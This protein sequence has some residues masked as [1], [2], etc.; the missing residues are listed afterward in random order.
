MLLVILALV[1]GLSALTLLSLGVSHAAQFAPSRIAAVWHRPATTWAISSTTHLPL[2]RKGTAP[3][4]QPAVGAT[5]QWQLTGPVNQSFDVDVYDIDLFDNPASVVTAL[6]AGGHRVICYIS[7][8]SW[9]DWRPDA[10]QFPPE[11][12][13]KDYE[14]WPHEKWLDIR[15]IDVLGPIMSAR[16]DQCKANGFD[17]I[18]PDNIDGYTNDTG[19]DLSYQDQLTYNMWLAGEAHLR[20]LSIGLKNDSEQVQDLLPHYDWA[21]TEDCFFEEWC[22]DMTPFIAAGKAVFAAEYTDTGITLDDFCPQA[23]LLRFSAIL[24]HHDLDAWRQACP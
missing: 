18:E 6:H 17:A 22:D 2:I 24:K 9:E 19:F 21:L 12:I 13:G 4:W 3:V 11:V 20:G 1:C 7:V 5:W 10:N 14:G 8:G 15:R 23:K 16:F